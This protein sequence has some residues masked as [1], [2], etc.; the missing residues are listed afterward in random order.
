MG[1]HDLQRP[2]TTEMNEAIQIPE[3]VTPEGLRARA[4]IV[5]KS[6]GDESCAR[7]L[8]LAANEI[9]RLNIKCNSCTADAEAVDDKLEG[10]RYKTAIEKKL[11]ELRLT[12]MHGPKVLGYLDFTVD[13][14][15]DFGTG[16]LRLYDELEGI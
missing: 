5:R 13:Q 12:V 15:Y 14:A 6:F 2:T 3:S 16:I 4:D 7:H 10:N 8:E 9:L 1:E 11:K